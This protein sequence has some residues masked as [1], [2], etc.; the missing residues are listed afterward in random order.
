MRTAPWAVLTAASSIAKHRP[1]QTERRREKPVFEDA[2][3]LIQGCS[4]RSAADMFSIW[5]RSCALRTQESPATTACWSMN[6][7]IAS[8]VSDDRPMKAVPTR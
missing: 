8:G 4:E 5:A 2:E 1:S 3:A 6:W 7:R